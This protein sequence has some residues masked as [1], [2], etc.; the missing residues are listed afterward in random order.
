M[1]TVG[2]A[3][4][5]SLVVASPA[6][7]ADFINGTVTRIS[8][9]DTLHLEIDDDVNWVEIRVYG[10]D[11]PESAWPG[12][13]KEQAGAKEAKAFA[14]KMLKGKSATV[15]LKGESTYDRAVGEVFRGGYSLSRELL[16]QGLCWWNKKYAPNDLDLRALQSA[17]K[18]AKKGIWAVPTPTPPWKHRMGE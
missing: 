10:V 8:D 15:R 7:G 16:R 5:I 13:W 18:S 17:A 1:R 6:A 14:S 4:V 3:L 2:F 9:G 11:C 12:R